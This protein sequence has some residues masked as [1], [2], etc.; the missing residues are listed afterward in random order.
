MS[1]NTNLYLVCEVHDCELLPL[2]CIDC[3]FPLCG[4]CVTRDHVGHKVRK[5]SEVIETQLRQLEEGLDNENSIL[6]LKNLLSDSQRRQK[7]LAENREN[8]LR[9]VLNREEEL[10]EKAKLWREKM[11]DRIITLAEEQ[12]KSLDKDVTITSALL[13]RKNKSQDLEQE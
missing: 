2:Y 6:F 7:Q 12:R 3:D 8:L 9:N 10:I 13:L 11:T 5:V 4:D 1:G